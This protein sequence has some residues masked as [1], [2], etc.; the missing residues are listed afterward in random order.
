MQVETAAKL[1]TVVRESRAWLLDLDEATVRLK[2][3]ADRWSI[4][5]VVGH[6]VDSASNNHHRFI[7]A[8]DLSELSFPKYDQNAW[9]EKND[10]HSADWPGLVEL[11]YLYNLQL[12][13]VIQRISAEQLTTPCTI[14]PN[15]PC[16]LSFL[17]EDYLDHLEHH[18]QKI[19]ERI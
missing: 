4:A 11:W 5:E 9:V 17:V 1:E 19:R 12:A 15:E 18:L 8:Q 16:T 13:R 10:Y 14:G 7:R 3:T 2:P 6:M